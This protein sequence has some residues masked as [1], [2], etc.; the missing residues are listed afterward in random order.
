[1]QETIKHDVA[2]RL[3][4]RLLGHTA[5]YA[6]TMLL[7]SGIGY[8]WGHSQIWYYGTFEYTFFQAVERNWLSLFLFCLM[9]G[10]LIIA[11][12]HIAKFAKILEEITNAVNDIFNRKSTY[13]K[14]PVQLHE[15]EAQLNQILNEMQQD[16]QIAR[17]A[18]QRKNDMIVYLA[19]DLKTPLTSVLGYLNLLCDEKEISPELRQKYLG[20]ALKQSER[21]EELINEF[22][23][24][25]KYN[26]SNTV[27]T[28]SRVNL[29]V[30]LT[31]LVYEFEPMFH[32]KGVT[33]QTDIAQDLYLQCDVEKMERVFDNLFKNVC[34]Y[35]YENSTAL[36]NLKQS[37]FGNALVVTVQNAGKTIPQEKLSHLFEQ[38]FRIDSSRSSKTGGTGLGL[39]IAKEI[40]TLHHG[41]ITCDSADETITFTVTLP[42][43]SPGNN[44]G[45]SE[46]GNAVMGNSWM[47]NVRTKNAKLKSGRASQTAKEINNLQSTEM[48]NVGT[49]NAEPR[50]NQ[51][52]NTRVKNVGMKSADL[53]ISGTK[54]TKS[55]NT[56][57]G[58]NQ[59]QNTEVSQTTKENT[60]IITKARQHSDQRPGGWYSVYNEY[61][62]AAAKKMK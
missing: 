39:A 22:F 49:E 29:S 59:L 37:P 27:L 31:Q 21:L 38:F 20:T 43:S 5:I 35:C 24:V 52:Q 56:E 13:I 12:F 41:T 28:I 8:I 9:A 36:I 18:E 16:R 25:T 11:G 55:E 4:F 50:S 60:A 7:I 61:P 53:E 42:C 62:Q 57:P 32:A 48:K 19:H 46:T 14:L 47:G 10:C 2:K 30:M 33:C 15:V 6:A 23:E 58:S 1:M 17:E 34:N 51:L 45:V 44:F 3:V 26:F 54:N 40:I